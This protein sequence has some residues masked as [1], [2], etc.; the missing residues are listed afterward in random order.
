MY[1]AR[2]MTNGYIVRYKNGGREISSIEDYVN[3]AV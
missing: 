1:D 2:E 3:K